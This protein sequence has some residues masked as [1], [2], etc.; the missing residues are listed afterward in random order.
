[1]TSASSFNLVDEPW[2]PV[3]DLRGQFRE[4]GLRELFV[5]AHRLRGLV[6][7]SPLSEFSMLRL[8]WV[9]THR[10]IKGP[11]TNDDWIAQ[12]RRGQFD[13]AAVDAYFDA[14][15]HRFD[16]FDDAW[17]FLQVGGFE[18]ISGK[19]GKEVVTTNPASRLLPELATGNN[20]TL[21]DHT[22]EETAPPLTP[23][24]AARALLVAQTFG[25]GGGK[26][27]TS[28]RPGQRPFTHPYSSHA[29]CAGAV[30]VFVERSNLYETLSVNLPRIG[31]NLNPP[32]T[33]GPDD[34][35]TWERAEV[36]EAEAGVPD[37]YLELCTW[38]SRYVRL[39]ARP[40]G[41]VS[42]MCFAQGAIL[43][44]SVA[45]PNPFAFWIIDEKRGRFPVPLNPERAIWR[46]SAALFSAVS[47]SAKALPPFAVREL[48][49]GRLR[50]FVGESGVLNVVCL[51]LANDKANPLLWRRETIPAGVR[52]VTGEAV[53]TLEAALAEVEAVW[54]ALR[55]SVRSLAYTLLET[56]GKS[57]D[58]KEVGR[59]QDRFLG[60]VDF[61]GRMESQFHAFLRDLDEAAQA[62]WRDAA[63]REAV[64]GLRRASQFVEGNAARVGQALVKADR[65]LF[66]AMAKIGPATPNPTSNLPTTSTETA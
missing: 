13:P 63:K 49:T 14:W 60:K 36:R 1:M 20:P 29:P 25:L 24:Q 65:A 41:S 21:F 52:L 44:E 37:G 2:L 12:W 53:T 27:P 43:D 8:L 11:R 46:D 40:D 35:P 64:A 55:S 4:V 59:L 58:T 38:P 34:A 28:R 5:E 66:V 56:E 18:T 16:L 30:A 45:F 42:E 57:P 26:G 39:I 47:E 10:I 7:S 61:W 31:P 54:Q 33:S 23:A 48:R 22:L 6:D 17:P 15:R 3:V 32:H 9:L 50:E 19:E 51:G 62:R